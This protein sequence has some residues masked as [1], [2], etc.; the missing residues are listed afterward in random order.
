LGG[1]GAGTESPV[2][3]IPSDV[4]DGSDGLRADDEPRFPVT[5]GWDPKRGFFLT[6]PD[7]QYFLLRIN[8]G[9]QFRYTLASR[10]AD[11]EVRTSSDLDRS[12]FEVERLRLIL[13]G[14]VLHPNLTYGV[15]LEGDSDGL[16]RLRM[17]DGFVLYRAGQLLSSDPDVL[18]LGFGQIKPYFLR[19]ET[20][21]VSKLQMVDRSLTTEFFN[22]DRTVGAWVQGSVHPVF[23]SF[24][25]TNG[26]DSAN[27]NQALVDQIPAVVGKVDLSLLGRETKPYHESH[28]S[29]DDEMV[30]VL[31]ASGVF[32]QNNGTREVS[33]TQE[34]TVYQLGI[35]SVLKWS[36]FSL[37]AEYMGRWLDYRVGNNVPGLNGDGGGQYDHG[38]YV[39]GGAFVVPGLLEVVGRVSTI[40]GTGRRGGDGIE[41]GPGLNWY[42]SRSHAIKL[43][44]DLLYF[45]ISDDVPMQTERLD[46]PL[47][48]LDPSDPGD[49]ALFTPFNSTAAG[50]GAGQ[51]GILWRVQLQL[52]F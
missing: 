33:G 36:R 24:A 23:Y 38:F 32:D 19:Q 44:T 20:A 43:Q 40:W 5:A 47:S 10:S 31:G 17:I 41:A 14:H 18:A 9:F 7:N 15:Q 13:R 21:L 28:V 34:H 52:R 12:Y 6:D 27:R 2:G 51:R 11:G 30:W 26:I 50:Y 29:C 42:I 1:E 45:S 39:Q 46:Q 3:V 35:D 25:L 4:A 37:Q 16:G 8:G 49:L 22:I 48:D